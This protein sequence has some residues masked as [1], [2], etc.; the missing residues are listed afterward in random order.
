MSDPELIT[1]YFS[2]RDKAASIGWNLRLDN[3]VFSLSRNLG[4]TL[5]TES[6]QKI[7]GFLLAVEQTRPIT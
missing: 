1:L 5:K 7:D 6:L 3:Q 2:L 4:F